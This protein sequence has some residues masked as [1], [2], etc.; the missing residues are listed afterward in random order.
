MTY[1]GKLAE[2]V[3]VTGHKPG[4]MNKITGAG[5]ARFGEHSGLPGEHPGAPSISIEPTAQSAGP[6]RCNRWVAHRGPTRDMKP[7]VLDDGH[8]G[9]HEL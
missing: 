7:C 2:F 5:Q 3:K 8:E 1:A 4:E 9:G 6:G